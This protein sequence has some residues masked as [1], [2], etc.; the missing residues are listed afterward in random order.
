[1]YPRAVNWFLENKLV[2]E[3]GLVRVRGGDAQFIFSDRD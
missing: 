3:N 1:V 2:V